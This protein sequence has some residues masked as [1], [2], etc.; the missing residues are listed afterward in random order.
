MYLWS[1]KKLA[2]D[3]A[4]GKVSEGQRF[5]YILGISI[6]L[7]VDGLMIVSMGAPNRSNTLLDIMLNLICQ[8]GG[9]YWCYRS[10]ADNREFADRFIAFT[11]SNALKIYLLTYLYV[12][13]FLLYLGVFILQHFQV[14]PTWKTMISNPS[15]E[16]M[17]N[18]FIMSGPVYV[19][20]FYL[21][22]LNLRQIACFKSTSET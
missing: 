21:V 18:V 6:I 10:N 16:A 4:V 1:S 5:C 3:F 12:R 9:L 7:A 19:L 13:W 11:V 14:F 2:K 15:G 8:L 20:W 17:V 22:R